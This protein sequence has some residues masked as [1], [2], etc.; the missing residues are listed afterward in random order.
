MY[1]TQLQSVT[2]LLQRWREE[3]EQLT[4]RYSASALAALTTTH[5]TELENAFKADMN[6][7][8]CLRQAAEYGGYT[9]DHLGRMISNGTLLNVGRRNA[10]KLRRGDVP[11]KASPLRIESSVNTHSP[12]KRIVLAARTG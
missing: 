1:A 7:T 10:P 5:I 11:M 9:A 6:E 4:D 12:R 2:A 3:A 8:M